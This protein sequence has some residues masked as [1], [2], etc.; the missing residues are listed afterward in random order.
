[1]NGHVVAELFLDNEWYVVDPDF[2]IVFPFDAIGLSDQSN[3]E[4]VET[5]LSQK[6]FPESEINAYKN[7][8]Y[9]GYTFR[10]PLW[11]PHEPKSAWIERWSVIL[12]WFIPLVGIFCGLALFILS[13]KKLKK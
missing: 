2:G 9:N 3:A 7:I 5:S 6:G 8:I 4:L 12:S 11:E 1:L 13:I 10:H